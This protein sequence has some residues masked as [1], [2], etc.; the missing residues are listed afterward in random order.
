MAFVNVDPE[1]HRAQRE[2]AALRE[3]EPNAVAQ[4]QSTSISRPSLKDKLALVRKWREA[5]RSNNDVRKF[6]KDN[7]DNTV[8][9]TKSFRITMRAQQQKKLPL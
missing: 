9:K 1:M 6:I 7:K 3:E 2:V 5:K 4:M 8:V